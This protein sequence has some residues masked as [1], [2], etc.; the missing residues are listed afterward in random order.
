MEEITKLKVESYDLLA[1]IEKAQSEIQQMQ[2]QVQKNSQKILELE[3]K[4]DKK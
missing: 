1:K 3:V 2:A 4:P